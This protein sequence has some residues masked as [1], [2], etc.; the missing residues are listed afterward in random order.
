[1][2]LGGECFGNEVKR[3]IVS[4]NY[5]L[6]TSHFGEYYKKAQRVRRLILN[7]FTEAF[8]KVDCI[9]TPTTPKYAFEIGGKYDPIDVYNND[10][11]TIPASL[12]GLP[13]V[14][15]PVGFSSNN[16]PLGLQLI[17]KHFD[18]ESLFQIGKVI[19]ENSD[20]NIN[21]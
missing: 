16:L 19:E 8:S 18:E 15:I 9:L 13:C 20:F 12:A 4:G 6:S 11:F 10:L 14:S 17:A 1:M 2:L 5:V 3:R 7:D 21:K